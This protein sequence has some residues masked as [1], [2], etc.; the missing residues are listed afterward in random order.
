MA[1]MMRRRVARHGLVVAAFVIAVAFAVSTAH[2]SYSTLARQ[3]DRVH[4]SGYNGMRSLFINGT[5]TPPQSFPLSA[6]V[7]LDGW[8]GG[9]CVNDVALRRPTWGNGSLNVGSMEPSQSCPSEIAVFAPTAAVRLLQNP[10]WTTLTTDVISVAYSPAF[11]V[12][13]NIWVYVGPD[14]QGLVPSAATVTIYNQSASNEAA[15]AKQL[16]RENW[17]GLDLVATL[18]QTTLSLGTGCQGL[19]LLRTQNQSGTPLY[20]A[21]VLNVYFIRT[22]VVDPTGNDRYGY[23]CDIADGSSLGA[24]FI[25]ILQYKNATLA[26]E[27]GH[28]LS[29]KH[30]NPWPALFTKANIM[31]DYL[32][33][34][35]AAPR[36]LLTLGQTY[37]IN[38]HNQSWI[39]SPGPGITPVRKGLPT[40]TCQSLVNAPAGDCPAQSQPWP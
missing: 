7:L 25:D 6:H 10:Q 9:A 4:F 16:Y 26:H 8:R 30:T 35:V 33:L 14:A 29:L 34:Q 28:A 38:I 18:R 22:S 27:I 40:R 39:N 1:S 37:R 23:S 3:E 19:S 2:G 32:T 15:L 17:T 5:W 24:I 31:F 36:T 13:L 11:T 20:Q 21:G 12:Q